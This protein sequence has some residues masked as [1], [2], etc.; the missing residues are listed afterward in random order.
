[1]ARLWT[2]GAE[3]QSTASLVEYTAIVT[4]APAIETTIKR[5][6]AAAWRINNASAAEGFR[7]QHT[8]TQGVHFLRLY[9]WVVTMPA[10]TSV[11]AGFRISGAYKVA[12]RLTAAGLLQV[13]NSEDNALI[14]VNSTAISTGQW[15]RLEMKCDTTTLSSTAVE[16]SAYVDT[17]GASAFWNTSGTIDLSVLP[18]NIGVAHTGDTTFDYVVDDVAVNDNSGSFQNSYPGEGKVVH[19]YPNGNGD[20]SAWTGSDGNSTDNYLLVDEFPPDDATTYVQSN[21]S[22]QIDD[23]NLAATTSEI[24]S[25]DTI[26]LVQVGFR[27]AVSDATGAD[28]DVVLRVK[29]ASGGTV[30]E[31]PSLDINSTTYGSPGGVALL[32]IANYNLTLYDL[33]GASATAWTKADLDTAQIGVREAVTDTHF[34]RV[35]AIWL[36][37]EFIPASGTDYTQDVS[38]GIT[39]SGTVLKLTLKL[40]AGGS[41]PAGTLNKLAGKTLSGGLSTVVGT[42]TKQTSKTFSGNISSIV[43]TLLTAKFVVKILDG[44]LA[45]AGDLTKLTNKTFSGGVTPTGSIS[46]IIGKVL[47]GALSSITGSLSTTRS[48]IRSFSG[49][50][51][52]SGT[53]TKE[54]TKSFSGSVTSSGSLLKSISKFL[55]GTLTSAGTLTKTTSKFFSGLL[56]SAGDLLAELQSGSQTF[57][58]DLSG[59]LSSSGL[60]TKLTSKSFTGSLASGGTLLK[61]SLKNLSGTITSTGTLSKL[62][63]KILSGILTLAGDLATQL[64]AGAQTFFKDLAGTLSSSGEVSK[65]ITKTFAGI[66]SFS[67][68]LIKSTLKNLA[69]TLVSSGTVTRAVS[70]L[71]SGTLFLQGAL[72]KMLSKNLSGNVTPGGT[73]SKITSKILSGAITSSGSLTVL[74][75]FAV[76]LEGTLNFIGTLSRETNKNL[77]GNITAMGSIS[78]MTSKLLSGI[79]NSIVG[80]LSTAMNFI[81]HIA[82]VYLLGSR[83]LFLNLLGERILGIGLSGEKEDEINLSGNIK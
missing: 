19:L 25:G 20:N 82:K 60:L 75:V 51:T 72:E 70:K 54:S 26:T 59:T 83:I 77:S 48:Y 61:N 41:T 28:P 4:N 67:G 13:F 34:V 9:L 39:P 1:M 18:T 64:N 15:Y 66:L 47:S 80:S 63:G 44:A 33:P 17:P 16:V 58:Q 81:E 32:P 52:P 49:T 62:V 79:I 3:L 38:G 40:F 57:F 7:N 65:S 8:T 24:G 53:M 42:V 10:G 74:R 5:S 56:E 36:V 71:L 46:K 31:S 50:V 73:L 78:K 55:S 6:G 21:T 68:G 45:L 22:G 43:G 11:F 76:F 37:V 23:Y 35:S 29:A 69:G 12:F 27:N 2:G 14:G 30:E